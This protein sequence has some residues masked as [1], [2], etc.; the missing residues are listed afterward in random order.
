MSQHMCLMYT[1]TI[2]IPWKFR[3]A[4]SM[5]TVFQGSN[6]KSF[7]DILEHLESLHPTKFALIPNL[8]TTAH[9]ILINQAP[10]NDP[11]QS[12]EELKHGFVQQSRLRDLT[13]YVFRQLIRSFLTV[14]IQSILATNLLLAQNELK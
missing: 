8:L 9:L 10:L 5:F 7:S 3:Q 12:F 6:C 11:F 13:I 14:S 1:K 2:Y 4:F